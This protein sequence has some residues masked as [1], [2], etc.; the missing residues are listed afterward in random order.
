MVFDPAAGASCQHRLL[1]RAHPPEVIASVTWDVQKSS[2]TG[3]NKQAPASRAPNVHAVRGKLDGLPRLSRRS[4]SPQV[5]IFSTSVMYYWPER[6]VEQTSMGNRS[7]SPE[8]RASRAWCW[9]VSAEKCSQLSGRRVTSSLPGVRASLRSYVASLSIRGH[10]ATK[11]DSVM[12]SI[13]A[14]PAALVAPMAE[15][16]VRSQSMPVAYSTLLSSRELLQVQV[17]ACVGL[18]FGSQIRSTQRMQ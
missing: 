16:N 5:D 6:Y 14:Q 8:Q 10:M 12:M 11:V 13:G 9:Q 1:A 15:H 17:R 2:E 3:A 4:H 18:P 7:G